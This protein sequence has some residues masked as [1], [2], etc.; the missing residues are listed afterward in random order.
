[1]I[2]RKSF[3]MLCVLCAVPVTLA[4]AAFG[5]ASWTPFADFVD[6]AVAIGTASGTAT[7]TARGF[8]GDVTVTLT[9]EDGWI[10]QVAVEAPG[11]TPGIGTNAT[12]RAPDLIKNGNRAKFEA[13]SGATVS[14]NGIMNAAQAAIDK[15]VAEQAAEQ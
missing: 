9:I 3:F 14:S 12:G 13:V 10:T 2:L 6:P 8:G 15:I 4:L 11:E 7:G 5:C 1:M